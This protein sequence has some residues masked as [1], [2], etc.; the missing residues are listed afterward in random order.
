[1]KLVFSPIQFLNFFLSKVSF[2]DV[3]KTVRVTRKSLIGLILNFFD[4][5][6]VL[7]FGSVHCDENI[8]GSGSISLF[9]FF[10]LFVLFVGSGYF[11]LNVVPK[12][13]LKEALENQ[14]IENKSF[15]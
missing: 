3:I 6:N 11:L 14:K 8:F 1:M 2:R 12:G 9:F 15:H 7:C 10:D 13:F 5:A 4:V